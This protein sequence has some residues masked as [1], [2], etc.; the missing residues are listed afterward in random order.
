[1]K[2][3]ERS[4]LVIQEAQLDAI[5]LYLTCPYPQRVI[6]GQLALGFLSSFLSQ[7]ISLINPSLF[8]SL[9]R[10]AVD[11]IYFQ[12]GKCAQLTIPVFTAESARSLKE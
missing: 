4:L 3:E 12:R 2:G 5:D 11:V 8:I 6:A 7:C 1:M 9:M 10:I